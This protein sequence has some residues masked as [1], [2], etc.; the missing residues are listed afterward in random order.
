M[1]GNPNKRFKSAARACFARPA[2]LNESGRQ[3]T[4]TAEFSD[5]QGCFICGKNNPLGLKVGFE[6]D[7]GKG[8]A[9][10]EVIF[11]EHLQGWEKVVHGG[12]LAALLDETMIYAAGAAGFRCVTGEITVR[13]LKP[14]PTGVPVRAKGRFT[15]RKGRVVSAEA[16]LFD[17][18]EELL[19]RASG[20]LVR[21]VQKL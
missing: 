21:L 1:E 10:T 5:N 3:P 20:K 15:G 4:M 8:T 17:H 2:V 9:E 14:V 18:K 16:G 11:P 7:R 12:L 13:Y 19:A 6:L